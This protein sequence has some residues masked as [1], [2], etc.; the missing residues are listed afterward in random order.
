MAVADPFVLKARLVEKEES[1]PD[2]L[3][4]QT[5]DCLIDALGAVR[6]AGMDGLAEQG[7]SGQCVGFDKLAGREAV[8]CSGDIE[9]DHLDCCTHLGIVAPPGTQIGRGAG[10]FDAGLLNDLGVGESSAG[11]LFPELRVVRR[12]DRQAEAHGANNDAVIVVWLAGGQPGIELVP[13]GAQAAIDGIHHLTIAHPLGHQELRCKADLDVA[14]TF[15]CIVQHQLVGHAKQR[16][17][18]LHDGGGEG[19]AAQ[20]FLQAGVLILEDRVA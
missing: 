5:A 18:G 7:P 10:K 14:D 11:V 4:V 3:G 12:K 9:A 6:L 8:L 1:V 2:T 17:I 15:G 13:R 16:C 20:V 19:K